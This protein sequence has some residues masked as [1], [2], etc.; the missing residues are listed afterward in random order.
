VR[1]LRVL[2]IRLT[3]LFTARQ[4]SQQ[5]DDELASHLEMH[6]EDN[7]RRGLTPEEARRQALIALG[8]SQSVRDAY[9]HRGSLPALE[10]LWQDVGF[11]V[12]MLKKSPGFTAVAV[13]VLALG[14]GANSAMFS[15]INALLLRP[16]NGRAMDGEFVGLYSGDRTRPDRYRF[17]SYPEYVDLRQDNDVFTSL[18]AESPINPGLDEGGL[19]RRVRAVAVS[20]NYFSTLG[21]ELA[22]GRAFTLDEERPDS[23]AAVAVVS[24]P[25]WIR[26]GRTPDI[27][28]RSITINGH[29]L[30]IVGV[31]PRGFT[32][33][34]PVMSADLWIPFATAAL[35]GV[36][37]EIGPPKRFVN[38]RSVQTLFLAGTLKRGVSTA[39]AES[40]LVPLASSF[41]GAYPQFNG[42]QQLVVH[43]RSRVAMGPRPRSD[44]GPAAGAVV[45]MTIAGLVLLVACLNLAN[46]VLARGAVRRQ[47]IAIR[48]ALGAGRARVVRQLLVEGLMLSA[49]G[50]VAA[51]LTA[52]WVASQLLSSLATVMSEPIVIDVSPDGRVLTAVAL[53]VIASTLLFAL[54]PAW[55]LTRPDLV[56]TLKEGAPTRA[57]RVGRGGMPGVMVAVQVALSVALL[58]SAGAFL[59]ASLTAASSDPGFPLEGGLLAEVSPRLQG[60]D[61]ARGRGTYAAV[62]DRVRGLAGVQAASIASIVPYGDFRDARQVTYDDATMFATFTIVG[63]DYFAALDLPVLAGREFTVAEEQDPAAE[64]VA[65]VDQALA[66]RLFA[67][68]NPLGQ[69]VRLLAFDQSEE[70]VRIVGVVGAVRDDAL[71]PPSA[72][73]YVAFGRHYRGEMT[74]HVRTAHG[75]EAAMLETVRAAIQNADA[76]LPLL[77]LRTMTNYRDATS[78]LWAV[79]LAAKIFVAFGMIAGV[80]ATAGVYGLRAYLVTQRRREIGIRIA[81]GA[82]RGAIIGQFV[83]EGTWI[84]AAGLVAGSV[85]AVG[86]VQLL[87]QSGLLYEV[88]AIDPLVFSVAPLLL[89][90]ATAAASYLPARRAL[91]V[92]PTVALKPE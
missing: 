47:E 4:R 92:D 1:A 70:L 57:T 43:A 8:G 28:G 29:A 37:E 33:A 76:R 12:R 20:A 5:F 85:L 34:M 60:L 11:A 65:I 58:I 38:D 32:G 52:W 16:L 7:I 6:V 53:S 41:E 77:S 63:A 71:Q 83:K 44:A 62:L 14:I 50:G 23:A 13:L 82:T 26:H 48:L 88:R 64:P 2:W 3:G 86:L 42:N 51:L 73:V 79:T 59:R 18:L 46:I 87:R 40:R 10:S 15:L 61:E 74:I 55:R 35:V 49:M 90:L 36:S 27:V 9:R 45:L 84:A 30:T 72:H 22:A 31:A 24:Y 19:T 39:A 25:Y 56:T 91:S 80:L 78:S 89:A 81:L 17:F 69:S 21:V 54:G 67:G 75:S 66:D 68:Q